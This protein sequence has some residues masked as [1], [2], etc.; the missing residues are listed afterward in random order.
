MNVFWLCLQVSMAISSAL[1]Q[2]LCQFSLVWLESQVSHLSILHSVSREVY[3]EDTADHM[4]PVLKS[5]IMAIYRIKYKLPYYVKYPFSESHP[6]LQYSPSSI[7]PAPANLSYFPSLLIFSLLSVSFYILLLLPGN[8]FS[9]FLWLT[10][11]CWD[12][13][14]HILWKVFPDIWCLS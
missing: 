13:V 2:A 8:S 9:T 7:Y 14:T 6:S 11:R 4:I 3:F 12:S 5:Y 1:V 10:P